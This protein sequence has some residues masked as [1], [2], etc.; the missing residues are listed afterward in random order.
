MLRTHTCGELTAAHADQTV[1]L[2]GWVEKTRD[3]GK[4]GV[5]IDVRDRYGKT[6]LVVRPNLAELIETAK[7]LR[8]EFVILGKG[9]VSLRPLG[10]A[11]SNMATGEVEILLDELQVLNAS[12]VPPFLPTAQELPSED[13]RLK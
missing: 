5:F 11:N 7:H 2:C 12:K 6:Q 1:T 13:A 3:L 9:R 4:G 8:A 10:Q